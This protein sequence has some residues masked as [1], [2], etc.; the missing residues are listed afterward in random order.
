MAKRTPQKPEAHHRDLRAVSRRTVLKTIGVI[1]IAVVTVFVEDAYYESKEALQR[2]QASSK[3]RPADLRVDELFADIFGQPGPTGSF[4]LGQRSYKPKGW[5]ADNFA[6]G[7]AL[8][9]P[10]GLVD[11]AAI[12]VPSDY[13]LETTLDGDLVLIGGPGST[14]L[15]GIAFEF[16]GPKHLKR[17]PAKPI[18]PL[19]FSK[20]ADATDSLVP[21]HYKIGWDMEGVGPIS[22]FNYYF[23]DAKTRKDFTP[24]PDET[25]MVNDGFLPKD[26]YLLVTKLPNFLNPNFDILRQFDPSLWPH[27]IVFQGIHGLG[28]RAA[29]LL[30][31]SSG[32]KVLQEISNTLCG[33][34]AAFQALLRVSEIDD[35]EK[36]HKFQSIELIDAEPLD[37]IDIQ[38]YEKAHQKAMIALEQLQ[39]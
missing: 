36:F 25:T 2:L 33:R 4:S 16:E 12:Q 1:G 14:P 27:L 10:L 8:G 6:A 19:R 23:H 15:T 39:R 3:D 13:V 17:R 9:G 32:L 26:D 18:L 31:R 24:E 28:T 20:I 22:T 7:I 5:H 30:V 29:E 34:T 38:T 11:P 37:S 35:S 21:K